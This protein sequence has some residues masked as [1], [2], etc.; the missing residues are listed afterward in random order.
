MHFSRLMT[1]V[2]VFVVLLAACGDNGSGL[3][4]SEAGSSAEVVV[5]ADDGS[6][7]LSVP[8]EAL[9]PGLD[10]DDL[11]VTRVSADELG[12]DY[13]EAIVYIL[14]PDGTTL[15]EGAMFAT[16]VDM[17]QG[18]VPVVLQVSGG[19]TEVLGSDEP[20]ALGV[21]HVD[22]TRVVYDVETGLAEVISP[23][24][25]FSSVIITRSI[26]EYSFFKVRWS[27]AR[28]PLGEIPPA[29]LTI[30]RNATLRTSG[31]YPGVDSWSVHIS[32][33]TGK[34][35]WFYLP[36]ETHTHYKE[37]DGKKGTISLRFT[38]VDGSS[39]LQGSYQPHFETT[40]LSPVAEIRDRPPPTPFGESFTIPNVDFT[41]TEEGFG[42]LHYS[43]TLS[44]KEAIELQRAWDPT[45]RDLRRPLKS[46][47]L[48][49]IANV[50][51]D[52]ATA[53][54]S[55]T[56]T[57]SSGDPTDSTVASTSGSVILGDATYVVTVPVEVEEG[58]ALS[59]QVCAQ[60]TDSKSPLI[61]V[62]GYFTLGR[63]PGGP[64]ASHASGTFGS[65]GCFSGS[66]PVKEGPGP[67]R[68]YTS[69]GSEVGF[70]AEVEVVPA[71]G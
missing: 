63:D 68:A 50:M 64:D 61:G 4:D 28:A 45:W 24:E 66:V 39:R 44:W 60:D 38:L 54:T 10:P 5:E 30:E 33:L 25:H 57:L 41:C 16:T 65:D 13:D 53:T 15:G 46:V 19:D 40:V 67:T 8:L 35:R 11:T 17:S 69:D 22:G 34:P 26:A 18:Y 31:D 59:F 42:R 52:P 58:G 12:E 2:V 7:T 43:V 37:N 56:T 32:D 21:E 47:F 20:F 36:V 71:G 27:F 48:E 14:G 62:T 9:P 51:C 70:V 6:A 3:S 1:V 23:I 29:S 55:S 49:V